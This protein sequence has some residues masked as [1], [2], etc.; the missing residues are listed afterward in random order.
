[1]AFVGP[2]HTGLGV[3]AAS[4]VGG[5]TDALRGRRPSVMGYLGLPIARIDSTRDEILSALRASDKGAVLL[6]DEARRPVRWVAGR[7]L[8][9]DDRPLTEIG[10]P[11]EAL[12]QPNATL[13]DALNEMLK[14]RY[15]C[16][17]VVDDAGVY[18]GSV[19]FAT[20]SAEIQEMRRDARERSRAEA[21]QMHA[22]EAA[23]A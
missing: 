19:D 2:P 4:V 12:V 7:E 3:D 10:L 1:M 14:S 8:Q 5:G 11:P 9:R 21:D 17:T 18:Q 13:A 15:G 16:A 23:K 20:V 22:A 6:L